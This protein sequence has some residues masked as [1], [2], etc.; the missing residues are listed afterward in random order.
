MKSIPFQFG[1]DSIHKVNSTSSVY[2]ERKLF[3]LWNERV[4]GVGDR[5]STLVR[6]VSAL[7][8]VVHCLCQG[9]GLRPT[10]G[11]VTQKNRGKRAE[12]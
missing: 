3:P 12:P 7:A 1:A 8:V 2:N 4:S 6:N 10:S 9:K 11:D 5:E